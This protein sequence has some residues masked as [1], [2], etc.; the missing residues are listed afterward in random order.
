M[1]AIAEDTHAVAAIKRFGITGTQALRTLI[2]MITRLYRNIEPANRSDPLVMFVRPSQALSASQIFAATSPVF[3]I[4]D[5]DRARHEF[6]NACIVEIDDAGRLNVFD[7]QAFNVQDLSSE[8]IVYVYSNGAER[9]I[10]DRIT[11]SII[12]PSSMHSS[13]FAR[14]TFSSLSD[15]LEDYKARTVRE[16]SCFILDS[17]WSDNKRLFL[18]AKPESTMRRSL[19]QYLRTVFRNAEVRPEQVVDESHPVDIKVTWSDTNQRALIEIKW[20]GHSRDDTGNI[21]T[22]YTAS[23]ARDGAKQLADYLDADRTAG[24]GLRSRGYLVV[25]DAR[26]RGLDDTTTTVSAENGLYFRDTEIEYDPKYHLL[27]NDFAPPVRM[28]AEP[29][30]N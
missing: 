22:V 16:T 30:L 13:I 23:R 8:A 15:A 4:S 11:Y 6:D 26:R 1:R 27:R 12:N 18:R 24:P 7:L 5:P 19:H 29:I 20:L 28:F 14:P 9:F 10:I 3:Q 21:T 25:F 2:E 17:A